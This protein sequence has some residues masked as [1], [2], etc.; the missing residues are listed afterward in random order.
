MADII[1]IAVVVA[2]VVLAVFKIV[3]DRRNGK[4]T[5]CGTDT[6]CSKCCCCS[7]NKDDLPR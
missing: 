4:C 5:G 7:K 2:A 3:R 1:V 6:G